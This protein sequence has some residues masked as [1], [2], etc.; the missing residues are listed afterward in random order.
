MDVV[1]ESRE[2]IRDYER[3]R[4]QMYVTSKTQLEAAGVKASTDLEKGLATEQ[5]RGINEYA[6]T[7]KQ[8]EVQRA[9]KKEGK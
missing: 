6:K 5:Q 8:L 7:M 3:Q 2:N 4:E 1:E 9:S